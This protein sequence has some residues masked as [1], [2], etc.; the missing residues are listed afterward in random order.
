[1]AKR[2]DSRAKGAKGELEVCMLLRK[3]TG[4][5]HTRELDQCRE[6]GGDVR[7]GPL[8]LEVKRRERIDMPAWQAQA[9]ESA[10]NAGLLPAVV[11][12]RNQEDWWVAMPFIQYLA[13]HWPQN[14]LHTDQAETAGVPGDVGRGTDTADPD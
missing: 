6:G 1:M 10:T 13:L 8:L 12:R 7:F 2:I 5:R 3:W 9:C 14:G 11:W 4:D